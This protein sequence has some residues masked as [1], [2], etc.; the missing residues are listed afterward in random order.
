MYQDCVFYRQ[1]NMLAFGMKVSHEHYYI[2]P[3]PTY[4]ASSTFQVLGYMGIV[5]LPVMYMYGWQAS[6]G[7]PTLPVTRNRRYAGDEAKRRCLNHF[8]ACGFN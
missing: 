8:Q 3:T 5:L 6:P 7:S 1:S 2:T 4:F